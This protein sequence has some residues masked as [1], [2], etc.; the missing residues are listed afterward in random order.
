M[1]CPKRIIHSDRAIPLP[2]IL[3]D[4]KYS[5]SEGNIVNFSMQ[6]NALFKYYSNR[7]IHD[8]H[9]NHVQHFFS[10][11]SR[12]TITEVPTTTVL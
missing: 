9:Q 1:K 10:K 2:D 11:N 5:T 3:V 4:K 12:I 7:K 6:T 8:A